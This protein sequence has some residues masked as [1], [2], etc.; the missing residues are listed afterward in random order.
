EPAPAKPIFAETTATEPAPAEPIFAPSRAADPTATEPVPTEPVPTEP[1]PPPPIPA[2]PEAAGEQRLDQPVW[3]A[4]ETQVQ[5]IP[6]R[7][8]RGLGFWEAERRRGSDA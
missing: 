8:T 2:E 5:L 3:F 1:K 6:S 7:W 4:A